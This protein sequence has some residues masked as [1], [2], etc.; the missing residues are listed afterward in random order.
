MMPDAE[1]TEEPALVGTG[2]PEKGN[3]TVISKL[4]TPESKEKVAMAD[5]PGDSKTPKNS[6]SITTSTASS[7]REQVHV[8]HANRSSNEAGVDEGGTKQQEQENVSF[9]S[10]K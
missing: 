10:T 1:R 8:E 9:I 2:K 5:P 3:E 4:S 6:P 7:E